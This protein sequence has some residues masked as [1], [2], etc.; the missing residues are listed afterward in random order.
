MR[1]RAISKSS[2]ARPSHEE[3][4]AAQCSLVETTPELGVRCPT[5]SFCETPTG[6]PAAHADRDLFRFAR[7]VPNRNRRASEFGCR[8]GWLSEQ[9]PRLYAFQNYTNRIPL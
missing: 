5:R 9:S 6:W 1:I 3:M 2:C 8:H 4:T 7:L